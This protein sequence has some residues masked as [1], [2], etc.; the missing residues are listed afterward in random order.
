MSYDVDAGMDWFNYTS[1]MR[2]FFTDFGAY[3]GDWHGR[4]RH[5]VADEIDVA[6][7]QIEAN[8]LNALKREYDASNGWGDVEGATQ[9]LR[10][11]RDACRY[12]L[13]E[14]VEVSR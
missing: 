9:F 4:S 7:K 14:T 5:E 13:P 6:I 11:V 3:P 10:D 1:N 8:D 12:E 2:R